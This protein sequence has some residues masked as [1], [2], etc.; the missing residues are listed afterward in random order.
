MMVGPTCSVLLTGI[1]SPGRLLRVLEVVIEE[2]VKATN[3]REWI[4]LPP[5]DLRQFFTLKAHMLWIVQMLQDFI[6]FYERVYGEQKFV[7]QF[8]MQGS[9][10][11]KLGKDAVLRYQRG[12]I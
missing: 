8:L 12:F 1:Q 3:R 5:L 2:L 11:V 9:I 10:S 7:A 4:D 6:S